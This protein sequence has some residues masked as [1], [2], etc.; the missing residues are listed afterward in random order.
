MHVPACQTV[1][2][3]TKCWKRGWLAIAEWRVIVAD[4]YYL[5]GS[6]IASFVAAAAASPDPCACG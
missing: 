4:F 1:H 6:S 5:W 2:A 3:L